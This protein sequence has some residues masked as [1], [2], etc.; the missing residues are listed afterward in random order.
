MDIVKSIN[1]SVDAVLD[2]SDCAHFA[3]TL[4]V[5]FKNGRLRVCIGFGDTLFMA[6]DKAY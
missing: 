2:E 4:K 5:E 3:A 1:T 6:K